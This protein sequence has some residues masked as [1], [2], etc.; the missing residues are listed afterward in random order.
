MESVYWVFT[1]KCN[2]RCAHCYNNSA[3]E[4]AT[5]SLDDL[6]A[7]VP[8]LPAATRR[9]I[10]SGGEPTT[11]MD[12]L[13]ALAGALRGRFGDGLPLV[14]QTNGDL[15]DPGRLGRI[16][17]AGFTRVDV[18]SMDRFHKQRGGHRSRLEELFRGAGMRPASG[19]GDGAD[20]AGA[21]ATYSFWGAT[22]DLW[23]GGNWARGRALETGTALLDP[24]HRFCSRWSG[25]QG[26]LDDGSE[27]QEVHVQLTR[28]YPCCPTTYRALGDAR[29]Q[30]VEEML[31]AARGDPDWQALSRGD[32]AGLG[33][34]QG[35]E[36]AEAE[37]R[38][39]A[40]GDECL[41]CDE[42]M[43]EKFRGP[44]GAARPEDQR[45]RFDV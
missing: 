33:A 31:E 39:Q 24:A 16:L 18:V 20:A 35:V 45:T 41:W 15:L 11:E 36:R 2:D 30:S 43:R 23:L 12:K 37:A 17:Q 13:V 3:P 21:G 28:V 19:G 9:V 40:L 10:L 29:D 25:A 14:L 8:N 22:E 7:V 1:L 26:F 27:R 6:L 38:I 32:P 5:A 34:A 42:Y 4:A 44:G